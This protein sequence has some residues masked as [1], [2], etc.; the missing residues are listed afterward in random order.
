MRPLRAICRLSS[1]TLGSS[2]RACRWPRS[3]VKGCRP[4]QRFEPGANATGWPGRLEEVGLDASTRWTLSARIFRRPAPA[5]RHCPRH[6]AGTEIRHA[7]RTHLGARHERPGADRR[8]AARPAGTRHD[9]AYLFIS[10]DLKVVRALANDVIVM[11]AGKGCRA[12]Q[13]EQ[14]FDR[15]VTDYTKALMAAAFNL[16]TAAG[17]VVSE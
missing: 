5:H 1:R 14:I 15:P 11:R 2:A 16:E 10:H 6:G 12:R 8:S 9:L 7:G 4:S 17:G 13:A 3:S